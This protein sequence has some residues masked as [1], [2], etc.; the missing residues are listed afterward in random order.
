MKIN[1]PK[2]IIIRMP[3]WLGDAVMGTPILQDIK[4]AYPEIKLTVLCHEAIHNLLLQNPYIDDFIVFSREKKHS[5][6]EKN[7]IFSL[8]REKQFDAGI[9]LTRSFSSAWWFFRSG[10][11]NRIG[12]QDHYRSPLLTHAIPVPKNEETEHQ[13]ITY[14][15]LLEPIDISRSST[16]PEL[17]LQVQEQNRAKELLSEYGITQEHTLIGINPGA[18]FGSAKCWLPENFIALTKELEKDPTIRV[19]YFGDKTGKPLVDDI[20]NACSPRTVN[21]AAKTDLRTLIALI[22]RSNVFI[23]NDSGPMH[24]AAAL[25]TPLV[26]IFGS[27]NEIKTGPYGVQNVIHKHVACSPCYLRACPT[28]FR[29]MKSITVDDVLNATYKYLGK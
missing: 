29:C 11:K 16:S 27:T 20:C 8:I 21:L 1:N 17:F 13:V 2:Q 3:N 4:T 14:K 25:K 23:S 22:S 18:A 26:A 24:V 15:R 28:D 6:T 9:L 19:A 5:P 12:F 10:V 7:R